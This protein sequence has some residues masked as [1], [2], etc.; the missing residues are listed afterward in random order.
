MDYDIPRGR[1]D[2]DKDRKRGSR[3]VSERG[4]SREDGKAKGGEEEGEEEGEDD[5]GKLGGIDLTADMTPAEIQMMQAMGIPFSFDTTQ[6]K[7]VG[8]GPH[9]TLDPH[10]RIPA[11]VTCKKGFQC[12]HIIDLYSVMYTTY[13]CTSGG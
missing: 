9:F 6:G 12:V 3:G 10:P 11:S 1:E 2:K 4:S 7:P 13:L 5:P 8:R